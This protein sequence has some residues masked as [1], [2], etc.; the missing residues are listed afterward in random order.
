MKKYTVITFL[1]FMMMGLGLLFPTSSNAVTNYPIEA[2]YNPW[3]SS[4]QTIGSGEAENGRIFVPMRLLFETY[5]ATVD[6]EPQTKSIIA[7][8]CDGAILK[9][10]LGSKTVSITQDNQTTY[11]AMDVIPKI[12]SGRAFVPLRFVAENLMCDVQWVE[13]EKKVVITK[14][15]LFNL[16]D[17]NQYT[18]N[19]KTEDYYEKIGSGNFELV[20]KINGINDYFK[21]ISYDYLAHIGKVEQTDNQ[22]HLVSITVDISDSRTFYQLQSYIHISA[23]T[24]RLAITTASYE[25]SVNDNYYVNNNTVWLPEEDQVLEINDISGEVVNTYNYNNIIEKCLKINPFVDMNEVKDIGFEFSNGK[26]MLLC[27]TDKFTFNT[28]YY[29]LVNLDTHESTNL[30]SELIP[31]ED[32]EFFI[33]KDLISPSYYLQFLSADENT[34][35]FNYAKYDELTWKHLPKEIS[36]RFQ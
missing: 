36:Y 29:V 25:G 21:N 4:P 6:W 33:R 1:L 7:K 12:K 16:I 22:N 35:Y 13:K 5:D 11:I 20:G 8:R 19:L 26:H 14:E 31:A 10:S 15:Y 3:D 34:L 24:S 23:N 28:L 17:S 9:M 2:K 27:Y 32:M 18:I 30:T